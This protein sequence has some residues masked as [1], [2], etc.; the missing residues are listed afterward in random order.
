V[1]VFDWAL[2]ETMIVLGTA[3][4]GV[5]G[6]GDWARFVVTP[7]LSAQTADL[8]LQQDIN[9]ELVAGL[10]PDLILT[11]PFLEHLEPQLR[12]IAPVLNLS[13]YQDNAAPLALRRSVTT[14]LAQ[15]IGKEREAERY[16]ADA[17]TAFDAA[18]SRLAALGPPPLLIVSFIDARH[19]R[20]YGG[21]SLFQ[22]VLSRL[23]LPN[24][25]RR[26]V[27]S[28]GY[29][30]VGV[31]DLAQAPDC[32]VVSFDPLPPD[33]RPA[34]ARSTLWASLPFVRAGRLSFLAP[35]QPFGGMPAALRFTRLLVA[36]LEER[37][38]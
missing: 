22:N 30:T 29:A 15:R 11:S 36:A 35:T 33:V 2:A 21:A 23:G 16:L 24:A 8:G 38:Q 34:L 12:R 32:H 3:P 19:V 20:I 14:A 25:W 4:L 28:F 31:E 18:R 13:I 26:D 9:F 5:V 37:R 17:D 7:P 27:G 10:H 1:V 6:A